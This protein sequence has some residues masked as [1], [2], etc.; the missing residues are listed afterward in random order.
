MHNH[1]VSELNEFTDFSE[2]ERLCADILTGNGYRGIDPQG[3]QG[4]DGGKDALH[5]SDEDDIVF[6]FSTREDWERKL[7]EDLDKVDQND[8][9]CTQFVFVSNREISGRKKDQVNSSIREKYDW[10]LDLWD[11]ERLRVELD[12]HRQE[13]RKKYLG[14]PLDRKTHV[15]E[16]I[17]FLTEH[18][19]E[20]ATT[21]NPRVN[22][23]KERIHIFSVPHSRDE[24]RM[25]FFDNQYNFKPDKDNLKHVLAQGIPE[26][27]SMLQTRVRSDH[28]STYFKRQPQDSRTPMSPNIF[29]PDPIVYE[30]NI[31]D[32]GMLEGVYDIPYLELSKERL[33]MFLSVFHRMFIQQIYQDSF[34]DNEEITLV[35]QILNAKDVDFEKDD[36]LTYSGEGWLFREM[37]EGSYENLISNWDQFMERTAN[38]AHHFFNEESDLA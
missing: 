23:S 34:T 16:T 29:Q 22:S 18:R 4:K 21:F 13:L 8:I 24:H 32:S 38:K 27:S 19:D 30:S 10:S 1:T 6:H 15:E 14:I 3:I 17:E 37:E 2:F 12:N 26:K 28:F 5:Y 36:G 35:C 20:S 7:Y 11:V 31:F 9:S 25:N 33:E